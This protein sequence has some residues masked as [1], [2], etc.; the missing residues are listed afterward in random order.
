MAMATPPTLLIKA[1]VFS[2][3]IGEEIAWMAFGIEHYCA[4]QGDDPQDAIA[5]YRT[6]LRGELDWA[7][8]PDAEPLS[9]IMPPPSDITDRWAQGVDEKTET[10]MIDDLPI[11][12]V[13]R[14][15][16]R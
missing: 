16:P 4:S 6:I 5:N 1:I 3:Q 13:S 11:T 2:E 15:V 7:P 12:L 9:W 14:V 10:F 8:T